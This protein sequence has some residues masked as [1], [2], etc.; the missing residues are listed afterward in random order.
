MSSIYT[1][2]LLSPQEVA[3]WLGVPVAT[4]YRWRQTGGGPP[5][6]RVGRHVR[7]RE[8]EVIDWLDGQRDRS[9]DAVA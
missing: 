9:G 1:E 2:Q 8:F 3:D 6:Y 5:G 7:Y 4:V